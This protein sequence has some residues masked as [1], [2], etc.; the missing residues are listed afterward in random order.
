MSPRL[1]AVA[2]RKVIQALERAGFYIHHTTGS[3]KFLKHPDRPTERIS[4]AYHG[5]DLNR[6]AL[7]K[8]I[9]AAGLT[10]EEFLELLTH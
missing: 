6:S 8:I 5:R 4:I 9:K 7:R 10:E 3:H 2:P 1:P